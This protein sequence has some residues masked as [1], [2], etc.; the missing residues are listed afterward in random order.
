M[1]QT[2]RLLTDEDMK[3]LE[4]VEDEALRDLLC[5]VLDLEKMDER[6]EIVHQ[7]QAIEA[8]ILEDFIV[9]VGPVTFKP[10]LVEAYYYHADKFADLSVHASNESSAPSYKLAKGR[11]QKNFGKLYVHYI[12]N[13]NDGFDVCLTDCNKYYLSVLIK[14]AL[15]YQKEFVTQSQVSKALCDT[16]NECEH[17]ECCKYYDD[18]V[19]KKAEKSTDWNI[20]FLPRKGI[21]GE[22]AKEFLAAFP[23]DKITEYGFTFADRTKG[24]GRH[25]EWSRAVHAL[26]KEPTGEKARSSV[27]VSCDSWKKAIEDYEEMKKE[28]DLFI[29]ST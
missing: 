14:N 3:R 27:K 24:G 23:I 21:K 6:D 26:F 20:R 16:C 18:I 7:L 5:M 15:V 19:L 8:V 28:Y 2:K 10:L 13:H 22:F 9:Q 29:R 17:G 25:K 4:R 1:I 11:Q 12:K